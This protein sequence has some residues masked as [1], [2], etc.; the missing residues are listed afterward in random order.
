M[1]RDLI[2]GLLTI[3]LIGLAFWV[4][5][6]LKSRDKNG[7]DSRELMSDAVNEAKQKAVKLTMDISSM[8]ITGIDGDLMKLSNQVVIS[9]PLPMALNATRLDYA[10][11]IN[12]VQVGEGSHAQP[13][14]LPA[15]G[16]QTIKLPMVMRLDALK[17]V[18]D[19]MD[20]AGKDSA[21]YTFL[22]TVHSDIPVAGSRKMEFNIEEK[23]P[24][25]RMLKLKTGDAD[26]RKAGLKNT[27]MSM[28]M[29]VTNPNSFAIRMKDAEY[30][31]TIDG[32]STMEGSMQQEV[33]LPAKS[34]TPISMNMNMKTGKALKMG[35]K[36]L[37]DNKDS[38]YQ[39][40][41]SGLLLSESKL[42]KSASMRIKDEG[43]LYELKQAIK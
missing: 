25:V 36:M 22:N 24:V 13:I 26:F 29:Q 30:S 39:L 40:N 23:L 38:R 32:A 16:T 28:T 18:T 35:W 14:H 6:A 11:L 43:S 17:S 33:L 7:K 41:F 8:S 9:N 20:A 34:T 27:S 19:R 12:G 21:T 2:L 5:T 15:S 4:G 42:I 31:M 1:S 3:T 37:F 10:M